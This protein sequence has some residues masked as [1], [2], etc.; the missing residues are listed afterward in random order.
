[1]WQFGTRTGSCRV[2]TGSVELSGHAMCEV[3]QRA[4]GRG[5][6]QSRTGGDW[7]VVFNWEYC[8]FLVERQY[9]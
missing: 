2:G 4:A 1:M 6:E 3:G 5:T 7:G 8:I 9:K